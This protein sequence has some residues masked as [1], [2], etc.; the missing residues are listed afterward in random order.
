MSDIGG[1]KRRTKIVE[2]KRSEVRIKNED[3]QKF[4]PMSSRTAR[5]RSKS[6]YLDRDDERR[7]LSPSME[8]KRVFDRRSRSKDRS[9]ELR[10]RRRSRS[11]DRQISRNSSEE[12]IIEMDPDE[13]ENGRV[14]LATRERSISPYTLAMDKWSN[15][16]TME[17]KL[18]EYAQER[19]A[20]YDASPE[21]H[22]QYAEE[23]KNFWTLRYTE[24]KNSGRNPDDHDY[25]AEWIPYWSHKSRNTKP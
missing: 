8:R 17:G 19:L 9:S 25:L 20:K 12:R 21:E 13:R 4:R 24:V 18:M 16:K 23:W 10:K 3:D 2:R 6:P 7:S 1:S 15:F 5:P 22:P 11:N 14:V